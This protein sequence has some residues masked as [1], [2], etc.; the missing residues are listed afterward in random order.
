MENWPIEDEIREPFTTFCN[1]VEIKKESERDWRPGFTLIAHT[2]RLYY[3][4]PPN[5]DD[6]HQDGNH[7]AHGGDGGNQMQIQDTSRM[8]S[9]GF[10]A[11]GFTVYSLV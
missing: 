7:H 9:L 8:G 4:P 2:A 5:S 6:H 11:S 10:D 1:I 3:H